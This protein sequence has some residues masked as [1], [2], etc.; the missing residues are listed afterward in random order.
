M[1][2]GKRPVGESSSRVSEFTRRM[3]MKE[4]EER[5][6]E[7]RIKKKN[8]YW[9]KRRYANLEQELGSRRIRRMKDR[10]DKQ[11]AKAWV[12]TKLEN[13]KYGFRNWAL[14][15]I[16]NDRCAELAKS[17]ISQDEYE[18]RVAQIWAE[19]EGF[20]EAQIVAEEEEVDMYVRMHRT[21]DNKIVSKHAKAAKVQ[22]ALER[23]IEM[24]RQYIAHQEE[25][26]DDDSDDAVDLTQP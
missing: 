24:E 13:E 9:E 26:S 4:Q 18:A 1:D 22:E 3:R 8:E 17:Y 6:A 14:L 16:C 19:Y 2:K 21:R 5:E 10:F 11:M 23:A 12:P 15:G 25:E 7:W 20:E